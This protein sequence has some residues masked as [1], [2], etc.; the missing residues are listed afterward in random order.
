MTPFKQSPGVRPASPPPRHPARTPSQCGGRGGEGSPTPSGGWRGR[1]ARGCSACVWTA[2]P[3]G[4]EAK[5]AQRPPPLV[6]DRGVLGVMGAHGGAGSAGTSSGAGDGRS[7]PTSRRRNRDRAARPSGRGGLH[8]RVAARGGATDGRTDAV[9]GSGGGAAAGLCLQGAP[10]ARRG[11]R[12]SAPLEGRA[13]PRREGEL[14]VTSARASWSAP[15]TGRDPGRF[16]GNETHLRPGSPALTLAGDS[17]HAVLP[18]TGA[19][20]RRGPGRAAPSPHGR[21]CPNPSPRSS[22]KTALGSGQGQGPSGEKCRVSVT[23]RK[24]GSVIVATATVTP[25]SFFGV[26]RPSPPQRCGCPSHVRP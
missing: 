22:S 1:E 6:R 12:W 21:P 2:L 13:R 11:P 19:A 17:E 26:S 7:G 18:A 8:C 10:S 24:R 4:G 23:N 20:S 3:R 9:P 15:R 14:T 5:G 16:A 25:A